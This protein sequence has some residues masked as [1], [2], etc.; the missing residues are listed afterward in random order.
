MQRI[1][2][3]PWR[4]DRSL[5][6][7]R[8]PFFVGWRLVL[9]K[10]GERMLSG[11][12]AWSGHSRALGCEVQFCGVSGGVLHPTAHKRVLGKMQGRV[13]SGKA[14]ALTPS[15]TGVVWMWCSRQ[16]FECSWV[17]PEHSFS[18]H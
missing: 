1:Q 12:G 6:K 18:S 3:R 7:G 17:L 11:R 14:A 13:G 15:P 2:D 8:A 16:G 5:L 9:K 10:K 4:T